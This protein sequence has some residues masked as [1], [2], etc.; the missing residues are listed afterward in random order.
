MAKQTYITFGTHL[1]LELCLFSKFWSRWPWPLTSR[2]SPLVASGPQLLL[3]FV[4]PLIVNNFSAF[5]VYMRGDAMR[6]PLWSSSVPDHSTM[7]DSVG[8]A[9]QSTQDGI[10]PGQK[11]SDSL[12]LKFKCRKPN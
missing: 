11:H 5:Y 1:A 7:L 4:R 10:K 8:R 12:I 6:C 3:A 2:R 9:E